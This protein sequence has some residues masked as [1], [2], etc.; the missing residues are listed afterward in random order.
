MKKILLAIFSIILVILVSEYLPRI[1]RDID[2]PHV[3]INE[4]VTY[5]TY[6]EKDVKKEIN[7]ISY[8]DIKD[9]DISKKK[10]DKIMEYKEYMGG[11]KKF[12]I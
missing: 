10:M 5:K 4:N 2:E 11:I 8:E 9:I 12:V 1:N 3:E 7:D 6:G